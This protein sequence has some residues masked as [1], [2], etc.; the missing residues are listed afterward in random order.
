MAHAEHV[1]IDLT[2]RSHGPAIRASA[3]TE[4]WVRRGTPLRTSEG[5]SCQQHRQMGEDMNDLRVDTSGSPTDRQRE[6]VDGT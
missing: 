1:Q 4:D 3:K 5:F 2:R 6:T